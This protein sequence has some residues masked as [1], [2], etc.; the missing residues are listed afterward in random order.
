MA[1]PKVYAL[2]TDSS[3]VSKSSSKGRPHNVRLSDR[4]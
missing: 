3:D 4:N 1:E 2:E